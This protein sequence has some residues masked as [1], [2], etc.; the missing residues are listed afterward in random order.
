MLDEA[1]YRYQNRGFELVRP[2]IERRLLNDP[3]G[4]AESIRTSK[5]RNPREWVYSHIANTAGTMLE[6]G[7]FHLYRG[8]IH[9]LGPGNDLKKI[10]DDSIDVLTEMKV[11]DP[12]YAEKQ[13]QALRTNI[14]DI[15]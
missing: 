12:E 11:I 14:K 8:M 9:P 3:N 5:G 4:I 6:S 10:F 15:G 7:Q 2:V 13:K 1:T